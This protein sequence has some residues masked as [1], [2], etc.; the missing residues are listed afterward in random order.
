MMLQ[1][2]SESVRT[3]MVA[4]AIT[5]SPVA[6]LFRLC[7]M[8]QPGGESESAYILQYRVSPPKAQHASDLVTVL[9]QWERLL[10]RA[11]KL[12][13]AKPGPSLLACGLNNLVAEVWAKDKGVTFR[14]Q[15]VRSRLGVDVSPTWESALQLHQHLR[16]ESENLVNGLPA[17][18]NASEPP[19]DPKLRPLQPSGPGPTKPPPSSTTSTT[20]T[21][22]TAGGAGGG[23]KRYKCF[24]QPRGCRRGASCKFVHSVEGVSKKDRCYTCGAE[25][26][27]SK[28]CPTME[29]I[30]ELPKQRASRRRRVPREPPRPMTRP[31]ERRRQLGLWRLSRSHRPQRQRLQ[32]P[33]RTRVE[34]SKMRYVMRPRL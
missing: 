21:T 23:E 3:E 4:R 31:R 14:T 34:R 5:R 16:A 19:R 6:L 28:T 24:T 15:L 10:L 1:A 2:M 25:G 22:T 17:K 8:Y 18:P 20:T 32:L 13:I 7:T 30:P 11:D 29:G 33:L 12:N 9:R 27:V 26:H